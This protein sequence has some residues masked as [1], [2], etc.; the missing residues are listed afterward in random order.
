M[1]RD[2]GYTAKVADACCLI[3]V[4]NLINTTP[5]TEA[6]HAVVWH[7]ISLSPKTQGFRTKWETVR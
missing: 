3:P 7:Q 1:G 4:V 2:G 6:F 5:H